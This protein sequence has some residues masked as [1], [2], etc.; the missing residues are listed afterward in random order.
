M[1]RPN[2]DSIAA[3]FEGAFRE[4]ITIGSFTGTRTVNVDTPVGPFVGP[5]DIGYF[6][7]VSQTTGEIDVDF[8]LVLFK[9]TAL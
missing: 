2:A 6:G 5:C 7:K 9:T 8:E 4:S 1:Q 3:P